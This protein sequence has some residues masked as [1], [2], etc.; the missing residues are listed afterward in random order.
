[1][2]T[3]W[4]Y[5]TP[6]DFRRLAREEQICVL[7]IGSLEH[8]GEH[9]PYGT[10]ALVAH[11]IAHRASQIEPCV[12]FPPYWF[13]QVHEAAAFAGAVNF[14]TRLLLEMLE[15][16]LDQIAHN[17]FRKIVILSGHGG[18][19]HF[20]DYFAMSQLDREVGYTLYVVKG[21]GGRHSRALGD[22]WET[23]PNHAAESETSTVMAVVP[24]GVVRPDRQPYPEPI[25]PKHDLEKELP[26]VHS[27]LW[28]YA[29]YPNNVTESPS[30]AT[31]EK[32]EKVVAARARDLAETLLS[33][34]KD[35]LV[36]ALQSEFYQRVRDVRKNETPPEMRGKQ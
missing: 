32:G 10:D 20:L 8:H 29:M 33:I 34:K 4:E 3:R 9:L 31:K 17:G 22:L 14:P 12:V 18:N 35:E 30:C 15:A 26:G 7:P 28:W 27:G 19:T 25:L 24:D 6:E 13:G 23:R 1:M 2:Q 5:L 36:P 16:L 21:G 11:E